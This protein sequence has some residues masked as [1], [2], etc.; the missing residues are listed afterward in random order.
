[1][2]IEKLLFEQFLSGKIV[3]LFI[4]WA[5]IWKKHLSFVWKCVVYQKFAQQKKGKKIMLKFC[6]S[7]HCQTSI[8][9]QSLNVVNWNWHQKSFADLQTKIWAAQFCVETKTWSEMKNFLKQIMM[10]ENSELEKPFN[11]KKNI[12]K[13]LVAI[14]W[15]LFLKICI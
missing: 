5:N 9:F 6:F 12:V 7:F 15:S 3:C 10:E 4:I 11:I 1:M 2:D 13:M 14:N 8:N